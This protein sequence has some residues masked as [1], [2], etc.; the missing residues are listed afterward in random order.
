MTTADE[1]R[2]HDEWARVLADLEIDVEQAEAMLT[3]IH[4]EPPPRD[5]WSPPY[6]GPLPASLADRARTLLDRQLRVSRELA[7]MARDSRRHDKALSRMRGTD[8][9]PPVYFD[10]PA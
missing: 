10:S 1:Q 8:S 4:R 3:A 7:E 5:P 9:A 6:V 2:F